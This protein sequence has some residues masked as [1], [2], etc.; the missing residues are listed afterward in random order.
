MIPVQHTITTPYMV[1]PVHCYSLDIGGDLVLFDTGPPTLT[2]QQYLREN[3]NLSR[4]KYVIVTHC[5]VDHCG[6]LQWLEGE[7]DAEIY[8]PYHDHQKA[9]H[10]DQYQRLMG[11]LLRQ[12]GFD[13]PFLERFY[14]KVTDGTIFPQLPHSTYF[15]A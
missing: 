2:A 8:L 5:H 11:D 12:I 3:L 6:L 13:D 14:R 15:P 1:G 10:Q 7:T 9:T 4:L